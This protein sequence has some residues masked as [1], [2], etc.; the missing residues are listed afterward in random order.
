[1]EFSTHY[2]PF[3]EKILIVLTNTERARILCAYQRNVEELADF[4]VQ[5]PE[6]NDFDKQKSL[7]ITK[8]GKL[9]SKKL[10]DVLAQTQ[11]TSFLLCVPE[12]NREQLQA[13]LDPQV[14][15]RHSAIVPKNLC[16]ME[17]NTVIRILLD[18]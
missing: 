4:T 2:P 17:L 1:M 13:A 15:S 12:V 8:L 10:E 11:A 3:T 18:R 14:F 7:Q 5:I 16:A 9:L 6:Q